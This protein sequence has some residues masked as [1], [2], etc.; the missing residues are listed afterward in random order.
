MDLNILTLNIN[1]T[2]LFGSDAENKI[3]IIK[4][5]T[6]FANDELQKQIE[7]F[8]SINMFDFANNEETSYIDDICHKY[9]IN[10]FVDEHLI[11]TDKF[12]LINS[13]YNKPSEILQFEKGII[14]FDNGMI[15]DEKLRNLIR[16]L[17][18]NYQHVIINKIFNEYVIY[19]DEKLIEQ[20]T[21]SDNFDS[22]V[23]S[24]NLLK[25]HSMNGGDK[26]KI[27]TSKISEMDLSLNM[28][29]YNDIINNILSSQIKN[30][31]ILT[32]HKLDKKI[33][34]EIK[35]IDYVK[36]S[37]YDYCHK[38]TLPNKNSVL[39]WKN[40]EKLLC[41]E[42]SNKKLNVVNF[43]IDLNKVDML[44]KSLTKTDKTKTLERFAKYNTELNEIT[45]NINTV[46]KIIKLNKLD[47]SNS[48]GLINLSEN[49]DDV[50]LKKK[51]SDKSAIINIQLND[52]FNLE[53]V[54]NIFNLILKK[55][56]PNKIIVFKMK[57][58]FDKIICV[59]ETSGKTVLNDVEQTKNNFIN[60][61][62]EFLNKLTKRKIQMI[63]RQYNYMLLQTMKTIKTKP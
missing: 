30:I 56:K 59:C 8:N 41:V 42:N 26:S 17:T 28:I 4:D 20:N 13:Y 6:L 54:S 39:K 1:T 33:F 46:K 58:I 38:K 45:K 15:A 44:D 37:L 52:L 43:E 25:K 9:N 36:K 21:L 40:Y 57:N 10:K 48:T 29:F 18:Q 47:L 23:D 32:K 24:N 2:K 35:Y 60:Y 34:A 22:S 16:F 27:K 5:L 49:S 19:F 7:Q 3:K 31:P 53:K 14:S 50:Q 51:S 62:I 61:I 11:L 55:I 63:I 12:D